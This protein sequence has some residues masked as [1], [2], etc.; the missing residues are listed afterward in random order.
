[1][2]I[3]TRLSDMGIELPPAAAPVASYVPV[4]VHGGFAYVS[5]Q[6]PFIEGKLVTGKLGSDLGVERGIQ[7]ARGVLGV[8]VPQVAV[9]DTAFHATLPPHAYLYAI[10]YQLYRRYQIRRYGFHGTSHRYVAHRWRHRRG[11]DELP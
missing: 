2:N 7:A 9:F 6:L 3:V 1:M 11:L 8:G 5:G 4:V 10:P